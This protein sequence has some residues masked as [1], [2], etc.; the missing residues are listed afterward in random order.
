MPNGEYVMSQ[1]QAAGAVGRQTNSFLSWTQSEQPKALLGEAPTFLT[2][3]INDNWNTIQAVSIE[4]A[5]AYWHRQS[6]LGNEQA[7]SLVYACMTETLRRRCDAVFDVVR[8]VIF[9]NNI[10]D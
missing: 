10:C 8:T 6:T 1:T 9:D 3:P 7:A 5:T 2:T 4:V